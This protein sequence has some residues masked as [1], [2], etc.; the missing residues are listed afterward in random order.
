[1]CVC[2]LECTHAG[3]CV[4]TGVCA[5][6]H[7]FLCSCPIT[8]FLSVGQCALWSP[9]LA[10]VHKEN[11]WRLLGFPHSPPEY[12]TLTHSV[13]QFTRN[14]TLISFLR[15]CICTYPIYPKTCNHKTQY[16]MCI[17]TVTW[18]EWWVLFPACLHM[19]N[20][21]S[22]I[23]YYT[24]KYCHRNMSACRGDGVQYSCVFHIW[25]YC[26]RDKLL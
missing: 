10:A 24:A 26:L 15:V 5:C 23:H 19:C 25:T 11:C 1:M 13:L 2:V 3:M 12:K 14:T 6:A 18:V 4:T 21:V 8:V 16:T 7:V 20:C 22:L 17:S 9:L